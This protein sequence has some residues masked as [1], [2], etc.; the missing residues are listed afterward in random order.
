MFKKLA[1][2]G[3]PLLAL[4]VLAAVPV[5]GSTSAYADGDGSTPPPSTSTPPPA[6]TDGNPWHG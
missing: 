3:G 6:G 4:C 1:K 2:I 5:I